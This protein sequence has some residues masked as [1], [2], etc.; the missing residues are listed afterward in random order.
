MENN[1]DVIE[2]INLLNDSSK[3]ELDRYIDA[4][5]KKQSP[6]NTTDNKNRK[7]RLLKVSVWSDE[8]LEPVRSIRSFE[9][10]KEGKW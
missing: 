10:F 3:K 1:M 6:D 9:F 5:L 2:K 7:E 8:D 4:L